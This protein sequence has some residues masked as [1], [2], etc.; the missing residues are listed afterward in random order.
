MPEHRIFVKD[1]ISGPAP[2]ATQPSALLNCFFVRT[3]SDLRPD[4]AAMV[5]RGRA[6]NMQ[7]STRPPEHKQ[8]ADNPD[9]AQLL[10]NFAEREIETYRSS[11]SS[12]TG[13][14]RGSH[15]AR[16]HHGSRGEVWDKVRHSPGAIQLSNKPNIVVVKYCC[17]LSNKMR[18]IVANFQ[19]SSK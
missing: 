19:T 4:E 17:Q 11:S 3:R 16:V 14:I 7:T 15:W 5:A 18:K 6:M 12:L 10:P 8:C 9:A 13:P 2:S 1:H